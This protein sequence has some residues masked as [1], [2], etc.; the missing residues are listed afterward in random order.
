[1]VTESGLVDVEA[2]EARLALIADPSKEGVRHR[3]DRG[4]R[5]QGR[6]EESPK[7]DP[8]DTTYQLLQKHRAEG[9]VLKNDLLRMERD[10]KEGRLV[11]AEIVRRRELQLGRAGQEAVMN[12]RFRLD[13]LLAGEADPAKRAEIWDRELRGICEEIARAV[14]VPLETPAADK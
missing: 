4:R 6:G 5:R 1:V 11:D 2:S 13:P 14:T 7:L 12:L 9:E 10:E 3:H 8:N